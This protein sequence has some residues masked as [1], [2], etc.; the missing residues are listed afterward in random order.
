M[1]NLTSRE[2]MLRALNQQ[3]VDYIPCSFMSFTALRKRLNEDM[4][5]LSKAELEMG[6][7]SNPFHPV[8]GATVTV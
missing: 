7:D 2:R 1:N 8:C 4:F 3:D 6:L 5:E